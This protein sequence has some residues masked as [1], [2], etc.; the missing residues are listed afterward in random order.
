MFGICLWNDDYLFV[1]C[2]DNSIKLIDLKNKKVIKQLLD[3]DV[4]FSIKKIKYF[5]NEEYIIS[6]GN[7][8]KI[9]KYGRLKIEG[10]DW[11]FCVNKIH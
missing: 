10:V 4:N 7:F 8:G 1:C 6:K 2:G 11:K 9:K 3:V 5:D